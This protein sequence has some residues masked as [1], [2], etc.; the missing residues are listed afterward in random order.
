MTILPIWF[1]IKQLQV[2]KNAFSLHW[3]GFQGFN[4]ELGYNNQR[5]EA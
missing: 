4:V 3:W 1:D 5:V 2:K